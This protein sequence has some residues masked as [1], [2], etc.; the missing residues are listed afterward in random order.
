MWSDSNAGPKYHKF[1]GLIKIRFIVNS[2]VRSLLWVFLE[3]NQGVSR[4][5]LFLESSGEDWFSANLSCWQNSVS[6]TVGPRSPFPC[7]LS[8]RAI[9]CFSRPLL[10]SQL[11]SSAFRVS[12]GESGASPAAFL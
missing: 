3:E 8:A 9:P 10:G 2:T 11:A 4:L 5:S 7:W 12:N 6:V 1:S